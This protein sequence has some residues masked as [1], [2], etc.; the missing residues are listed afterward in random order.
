MITFKTHDLKPGVQNADLFS[1]TEGIPN[2]TIYTKNSWLALLKDFP[3][4]NID[5]WLD[6]VI[7]SNVLE[8]QVVREGLAYHFND[9]INLIINNNI[10]KD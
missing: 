1:L 7:H 8:E 4:D 10:N 3:Y 5:Q 6:L 2:V 9:E